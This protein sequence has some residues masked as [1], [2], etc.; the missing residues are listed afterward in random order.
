MEEV[1]KVER[2]EEENKNI[3]IDFSTELSSSF[4]INCIDKV[5]KLKNPLFKKM[6][7]EGK[8]R[9]RKIKNFL[10][11]KNQKIY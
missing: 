7:Y 2:G 11:Q 6:N 1:V 5:I 3:E 10:F 8:R 4:M 9:K